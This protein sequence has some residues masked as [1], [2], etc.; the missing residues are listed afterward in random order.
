MNLCTYDLRAINN[1]LM[2]ANLRLKKEEEQI[3]LIAYPCNELAVHH[4]YAMRISA[5]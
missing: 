2:P 1:L 5:N 4:A 3:S